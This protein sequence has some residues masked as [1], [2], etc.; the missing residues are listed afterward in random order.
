[1]KTTMELA[2]SSMR[3]NV[4]LSKDEMFEACRDYVK[5]KLLAHGEVRGWSIQG[6]AGVKTTVQT[7]GPGRVSGVTV[8]LAARIPFEFEFDD[9]HTGTSWAIE[10]TEPDLVAL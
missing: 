2:N 1:M 7:K 10:T 5:A 4:E 9:I 3:M 8:I 6:Y